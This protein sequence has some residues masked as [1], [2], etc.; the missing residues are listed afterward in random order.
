VADL[1]HVPA[2]LGGPFRKV[3]QRLELWEPGSFAGADLPSC[4]GVTGGPVGWS[5]AFE[6]GQLQL[7]DDRLPRGEVVVDEDTRKPPAH[8]AARAITDWECDVR[9]RNGRLA[10]QRRPILADANRC[11]AVRQVCVGEAHPELRLLIAERQRTLLAE[12]VGLPDARRQVDAE[13]GRGGRL[14]RSVGWGGSWGGARAAPRSPL[15]PGPDVA[16]HNGCR[17]PL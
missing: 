5:R 11:V 7:D 13:G 15:P 9:Q 1:V 12:E 2:K 17:R 16:A 4:G 6:R 14:V 10:E 3:E 8:L